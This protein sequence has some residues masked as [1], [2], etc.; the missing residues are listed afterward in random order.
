[1]TSAIASL[2]SGRPIKPALA[3]TGEVTLSGKVLP[4]GGIKEK[5][6]AAKR[7]GI[8]TI[9]LP[10]RNRKDLMEDIPEDLRRGMSF[11]FASNVHEVID[12][13]LQPL[14]APKPAKGARVPHLK[15]ME[16]A[17]PSADIVANV[18]SSA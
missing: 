11:I 8:K 6:L 14:N 2:L 17:P 13:A 4:V 7:A 3:M 1:M 9:I 18:P 12:A 16:T 5:V 15:T 10:E